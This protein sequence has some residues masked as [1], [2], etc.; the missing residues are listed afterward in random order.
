MKK[1]L[2]TGANGFVCSNIIDVLL[3]RGWFVYAADYQFDNPAT[4]HWPSHRVDFINGDIANLPPLSV[5]ALLHGAAITASP[6]QR[7]ETPEDNF[8]ANLQPAL[9]MMA[10]AEAHAVQRSIFVSSSAVHRASARGSLTEDALAAPLG[11]Y[12]VAKHTIENLVDTLRSEYGRD[13]ICIRLG[14]LYGPHEFQRTTRPH[15]SL[16]QQLILQA[17]AGEI[18][19]NEALP[20]REWT[21]APDVGAAVDALLNAENL[22]HALYHVAAAEVH[23]IDD[24]A[25][26]VET[27]L[28]DQ[29]L[30]VVRE[31]I[32]PSYTLT[33]LGALASSR[34]AQD[35]GFTGW[36][37]L[38]SGI[39]QTLRA[40]LQE[41]K[42][43]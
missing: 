8:L 10:Y 33:R 17:L 20:A 26:A 14:N 7:N 5:D 1:I 22:P 43:A 24:I 27:A 28:P 18:R 25:Q 40:T 19:I 36:T 31:S 34:L 15:V 29:P 6:D 13:V 23:S 3:A 12:S 39:D 16:I 11:L 2:V 37:S 32:E 42:H 21:F 9:M 41:A 30:K 38:K 35:T 4:A